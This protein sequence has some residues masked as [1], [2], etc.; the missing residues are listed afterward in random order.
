MQKLHVGSSMATSDFNRAGLQWTSQPVTLH[1]NHGKNIELLQNNTVALRTK[2]WYYGIV[3]TSEPVSVGKMFK[4]TL[5]ERNE[6]WSFG[7]LVS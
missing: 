3:C 5:M 2:S 7:G 6:R 1:S 4:V